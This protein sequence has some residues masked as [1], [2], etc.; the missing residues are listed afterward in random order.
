MVVIIQSIG[1]VGKQIQQM[2]VYSLK[3]TA[4]LP[5][6]WSCLWSTS[7]WLKIIAIEDS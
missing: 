6:Q 2:T 5:I 7:L 1:M 3:A 4:V